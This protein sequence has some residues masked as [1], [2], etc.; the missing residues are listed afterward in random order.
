M[1]IVISH[2]PHPNHSSPFRPTLNLGIMPSLSKLSP[3]EWPSEVPTRVIECAGQVF[4][5]MEAKR[6]GIACVTENGTHGHDAPDHTNGSAGEVSE[7]KRYI[8]LLTIS[9]KKLQKLTYYQILGDLP[10]HATPD[11]V[12][13]AYHKACLVYHPDKT[14]RGEEDEVFLTVK[15]A[16]DT[17]SDKAKRRAYDSQMPFDDTI[18]KG[19]ESAEEFYEVYLPVFERNL[20][21]DDRLNPDRN[22]PAPSGGKK[23]KGKRKSQ[24]RE[25]PKPPSLGDDS[26]P[27]DQVHAFYDYWIHFESWRDFSLEAAKLTNNQN[28]DADNVDSRYE[29]R[30]I[31]KEI[32]R[33][34]KSLKKDEMARINTLVERAMA[35]DPRLKRERQKEKEEKGRQEREKR[36][37]EE[38]E[39]RETEER[40]EREA[41][42]QKEREEREKAEREAVKAQKEKEKKALRKAKAT[43]RKLV[44]AA[45][46]TGKTHWN[47]MEIM[48]DDVEYLCEKLDAAQLSDLSEGLGGADSIEAPN[49]DGL[50]AIQSKI[51]MLKDGKSEQEIDSAVKASQEKRKAT[52]NGERHSPADVWTAEQDKQLQDGLAKYPASMEK[53]ER[54]DKISEGVEGRSKK[55][56]VERFKAI[57]EA[58]KSPKN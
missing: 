33:K 3:L 54:W 28:F 39:K 52:A 22:Q 14:G 23:N 36:E 2:H 53:N 49:L 44:L 38:R 11:E 8:N 5:D 19:N 34:A 25:P 31:Q 32:D 56:C 29:K 30:F 45:H 48:Y 21:F 4:W 41:R 16:F 13:K 9:L 58:L 40:A 1:I 35:A 26:T 57:R 10:L 15:A 6:Q 7:S 46:G 37:R 55:E 51:M 20:R 50:D 47:D 18:P 24:P 42:D 27:L 12:K 43:F 17:L